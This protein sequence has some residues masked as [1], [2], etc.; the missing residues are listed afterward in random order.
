MKIKYMIMK[1]E[2]APDTDFTKKIWMKPEIE[3]LSKDVIQSGSTPIAAE[4]VYFPVPGG[5]GSGS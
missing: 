4:G 3:I 1:N 5:F 2:N